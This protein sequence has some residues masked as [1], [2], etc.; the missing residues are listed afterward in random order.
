MT[1]ADLLPEIREH[2][3]TVDPVADRDE[4]RFDDLAV[5]LGRWQYHHNAAFRRWVDLTAEV[6][7]QEW[8]TWRDV[9][10]F[11]V[12]GFKT[13]RV[14]CGPADERPAAVWHSSGTSGTGTSETPLH[15]L[16]LYDLVVDRLARV[17]VP[18]AGGTPTGVLALMPDGRAWPHSSLAHMYDRMGAG[19]EVVRGVRD[20]TPTRY[21]LADDEILRV[22]AA[23]ERSGHQ[24]VVLSTSYALVQMLDLLDAQ[25]VTVA[26]SPWSCVVDTGGYKGIT[27]AVPR[28]EVVDRVG[29]RLGLG[30][31]QCV[32]EYGMSELSS[33]WWTPNFRHRCAGTVGDP[34]L[35]PSAVYEAPSWTRRRVLDPA[36]LTSA[37]GNSGQLAVFDLA[38][39]WSC[40]SILTQDLAELPPGGGHLVPR[41]RV[42]GAD[43][44]GCSLAAE[45]AMR[46]E[47]R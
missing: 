7:P 38:N 45:R 26:L 28:P 33:Q 27:R 5:R 6:P 30:P 39:V 42:G 29:R 19:R 23:Y 4:D 24:L 37:D 8:A 2:L 35:D 12:T 22:L 14:A 25:D 1:D 17:Y 36:T 18:D 44:K 46:G 20:V 15:T 32:G 13:T 47:V 21:A 43:L 10:P 16:D 9:T 41:G 34:G 31:A 40:A 11:P 3:R